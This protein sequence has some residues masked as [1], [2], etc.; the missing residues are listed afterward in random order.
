MKFEEIDIAG[1]EGILQGLKKADTKLYV[2]NCQNDSITK[3]EVVLENY[4]KA[5][6]LTPD[7]TNIYTALANAYI[8]K[9]DMKNT[10]LNFQKIVEL[11]PENAAAYYNLGN[12]LMILKQDDKAEAAFLNAIKYKPDFAKAYYNLG[13]IYWQKGKYKESAKAWEDTLKYEPNHQSAKEW[14]PKALEQ[15]KKK[16]P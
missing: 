4:N 15:L 1:L 7:V 2:W 11:E 14:L 13:V 16:N 3:A 12:V 5:K 6:D 9:K 10:L 8:A